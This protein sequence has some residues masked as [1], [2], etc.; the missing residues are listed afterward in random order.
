MGGVFLWI[1]TCFYCLAILPGLREPEIPA[2]GAGDVPDNNT[3]HHRQRLIVRLNNVL[4]GCIYK[5]YF[6]WGYK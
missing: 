5:G 6:P 2:E 1:L 3:R 4:S